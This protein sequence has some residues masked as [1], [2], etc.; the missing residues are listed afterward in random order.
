MNTGVIKTKLIS[1]IAGWHIRLTVFSL[2]LAILAISLLLEGCL[3]SPA[4]Q[5]DQPS[6]NATNTI[7]ITPINTPAGSGTIPISAEPVLDY[8]GL[9]SKL[10]ASVASVDEAV[11]SRLLCEIPLD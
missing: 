4:E 9:L 8:S 10:R 3:N 1:K 6:E 5:N 11:L 2:I 7:S